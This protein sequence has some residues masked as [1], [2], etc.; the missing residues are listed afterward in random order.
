MSH[1]ALILFAHGARDPRWAEPLAAVAD[2]VRALAPGLRV[3]LAFLEL[4]E[5]RLPDTVAAL[6]SDGVDRITLVPA[7]L[8]Q[9]GHIRRDLPVLL[10]ELRNRHAEVTIH[11]APTIGEVDAVLDAIAGFC[12]QSHCR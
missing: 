4:M 2:R 3:E 5:P 10:D 7:F 8:G 6:A 12:V 11:L 9:G 1:D